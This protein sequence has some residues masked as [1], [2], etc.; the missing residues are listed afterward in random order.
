MVKESG[1][2]SE[3]GMKKLKQETDTHDGVKPKLKQH[4][5]E[6]NPLQYM[7]ILEP[8]GLGSGADQP[9]SNDKPDA[10]LASLQ[11]QLDALDVEE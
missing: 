3:V 9:P 4:G 2:E 10:A 5:Y 1:H 6:V 7:A 11:L 8:L